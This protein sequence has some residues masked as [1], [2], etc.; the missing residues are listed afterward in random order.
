MEQAACC[1][2][3]G[4]EIE[5]EAHPGLWGALFSGLKAA[6][7]EG[8][9]LA[10]ALVRLLRRRR[11]Q[12]AR[13]PSATWTTL[14]PRSGRRR[15][16]ATKS[17]RS[18]ASTSRPWDHHGGAQGGEEP[19]PRRDRSPAPAEGGKGRHPDDAQREDCAGD[20]GGAPGTPE[21]VHG[22][23]QAAQKP[24]EPL[25]RGSQGGAPHPLQRRPQRTDKRPRTS[26]PPS[27]AWNW[28]SSGQPSSGTR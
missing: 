8:G 7:L 9:R 25:I 26:S 21:E 28:R 5:P 2:Y 19:R 6:P 14:T 12:S 22:P 15:R 13:S 11:R 24:H 10:T 1:L 17:P 4:L 23:L 3:Y 27:S 20:L 18:S 16:R